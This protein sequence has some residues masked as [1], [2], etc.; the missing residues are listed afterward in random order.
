MSTDVQAPFLGTPLVHL[1]ILLSACAVPVCCPVSFFV[2]QSKAIDYKQLFYLQGC[3]CNVKC[4]LTFDIP[5][6]PIY[7]SMNWCVRGCVPVRAC[8]RMR[9]RT[10]LVM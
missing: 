7:A 1:T 3:C 5:Y 9:A 6:T 4:R 8:V 2:G 10:P